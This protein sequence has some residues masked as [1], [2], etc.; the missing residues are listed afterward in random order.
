V[1]RPFALA[2]FLVG[3]VL[4]FGT[5]VALQHGLLERL[6][7]RPQRF[8]DTLYLPSSDYVK[9]V[10][11]GYDHFAADFLWLRAIQVF[12]ATL[13][14]ADYVDQLHRYF[15]VITDLDPHFMAAYSFG[16]LV[17]GEEAGDHKRGLAILDKGIGHN[18]G[19][20]RLPFEAA[21]FAFWAMNDAALAR[22]YAEIARAC[23]DA[24]VFL[25]TWAGYFDL[26]MGRFI[27][28]FEQYLRQ[29]MVSFQ[30]GNQQLIDIRWRQLRRSIDE[31]YQTELRQKGSEFYRR[32]GR[33]PAIA[34]LEA[35]GAFRQIQW[36]DWPAL[37]ARLEQFLLAGQPFPA[38]ETEARRLAQSF[39]RTGW[40]QMPDNP[41]SDHPLFRNYLF[42][43]GQAPTVQQE[44]AV[45]PTRPISEVRAVENILFCM[46]ELR[47]AEIVVRSIQAV[48]E[49]IGQYKISHDGRCPP[50][51][52]SLPGQGL[53][54]FPEPW[55]GEWIYDPQKCEVSSSTYPNLVDLYHLAP[56]L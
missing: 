22:R 16:N 39:L 36:P 15:E 13:A 9:L 53:T 19:K 23:P 41:A 24:P 10:T 50:D 33:A 21:F 11:L 1:R 17:I 12:G 27:L 32:E 7:R 38:D 6:S 51:L 55:G 54:N 30:E 29:Y 34:E 2:A 43:A 28:A 26:K 5:A 4:L 49:L 37:R 35:E 3:F 47:T 56:S 20:Y 48:Q 18:P 52:A 14:T 46:S 31:W 44:V 40:E 45:S 8:H 25:S 42:W